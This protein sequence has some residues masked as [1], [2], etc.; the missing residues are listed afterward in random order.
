MASSD[1]NNQKKAFTLVEAAIVISISSLMMIAFVATIGSR[2][3]IQRYKDSTINFVDFIRSVYSD[4][5]NVENPRLGQI[6]SQNDYCTLSGQAKTL[7]ATNS[8]NANPNPEESY[9]GRSGCAI[10]GKLISIG[11]KDED[12][13]YVYDVIGRAADFTN[14][15]VGASTAIEELKV[16]NADILALIPN[17]TLASQ[18]SLSTAAQ[19]TQYTPQWGAWAEDV[20]GD[21]FHG[22]IMIVRAPS[23]GAVRTFFLERALPIQELI[24]NYDYKDMN[25]NSSNL[26]LV[27]NAVNN[28]SADLSEYLKVGDDAKTSFVFEDV[29]ICIDSDDLFTS[30]SARN[31]IRIKADGHN[32]TAVEFVESDKSGDE[33]GNKCR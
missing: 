6:E 3:S 16:V 14:P 23:S 2:I 17:G 12:T 1:K 33:G 7:D 27:V 10:Y 19:Y 13:V 9:P 26:Q 29:N 25:D 11:E 22:A 4:V 28:K 8:P 5:I 30:F 15:I 32:S 20:K 18:V 31:N 21:R 24:T